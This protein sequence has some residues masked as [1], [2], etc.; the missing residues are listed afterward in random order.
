MRALVSG[1]AGF[2][3]SHLVDALLQQNC[4]V[5]V[6]DN[7]ERRVHLGQRPPKFESEVQ[8]IEGDTRD[9]TAWEKALSEVDVVYHEAAYQDLMP[10]YSK[11]FHTNVVGTAL[12]YEVIRERKLPVQKVVVASS[13]AV[14]GEGQYEC[15]TH[16]AV[17]PSARSQT[18][19]MRG[20]W[21]VRCPLCRDQVRPQL[22]EEDHPNPCNQYALSKY[23]QELTALRLGQMLEVPTVALRYS[24]TQGPRQSL[25]NRYSGICRIFTTRLHKGLPPIVYEDGLQ[26]RDYV[27]VAD[28]VDANI[29]TLVDPRADFQA[30]NVGSGIPLAVQ[31][32]AERL[33]QAINPDIRPEVPG[34]FRVGDSRHSVSNIAK[35]KALGWKPK[36]TLDDIIR[37]FIAWVDSVGGVP[38]DDSQAEQAMRESGVV[39]RVSAIQS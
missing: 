35:L 23:S 6:L 19:M 39:Q 11:F 37:D 13:Q 24:I 2:I 26:T 8:F 29:L 15:P 36:R 32:Y 3:G 20:N 5:V 16:G 21:E 12:L 38:E 27:H 14:Y 28:V 1:G 31:S 17:L 34:E 7:L 9:K 33:C 25:Y 4:E 22:L 10:V 18:Q 30:F